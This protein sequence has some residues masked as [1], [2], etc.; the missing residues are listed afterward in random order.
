[1]KND[2]LINDFL[3]IIFIKPNQFFFKK[4]YLR[5]ILLSYKDYILEEQ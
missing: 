3:Y 5:Y 2:G 1:M 4:N